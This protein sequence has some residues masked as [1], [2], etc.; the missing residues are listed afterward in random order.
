MLG[1]VLG[2]WAALGCAT[3][4][5]R[6]HVGGGQ[7]GLAG[8]PEEPQTRR[9][10]RQERREERKENGDRTLT[11]K[12]AGRATEGAIGNALDTLDQPANQEKLARIIASPP[13]QIAVRDMTANIVAGVF[14]GVDM[15][16]S[17][18]QI[19]GLPDGKAIGKSISRDISPAVGRLVHTTVDSAMAAALS[20]EN[21]GKAEAL[22]NRIGAGVT[23]GLA[24]G[25]RDEVGPALAVTIERDIIPALGRGLQHP[26][27]Q[28]A[29][30][31]SISSLGVGAA[32][33]TQAGLEEAN[34]QGGGT[35]R[36]GG[37][38]AVGMVAVIMAAVSFGVLFIVMTV[39]L[40]RSNRRQRE[41][42]DQSRQREERL[43]AV[44]EGRVDTHGE[45][46]TSQG[47]LLGR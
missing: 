43:L 38:L 23:T 29:I 21:A 28:A 27:M 13:M 33:G 6:D 24:N 47:P 14:Q 31:K 18:G 40:V 5:A 7:E 11:E 20:D 9:E 42:V 12:V 45:V 34:V 44:L 37:T 1:V 35:G 36:V 25:L 39:L 10:R 30:V 8:A 41:L 2:G 19:P 16:R 3:A 22:V 17:K 46:I 32:R 4:G 15:A 26:D